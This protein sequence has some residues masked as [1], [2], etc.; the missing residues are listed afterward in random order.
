ME[1]IKEDVFNEE[2]KENEDYIQLVATTQIF[3]A[4]T[5]NNWKVD[6]GFYIINLKKTRDAID[7][8]LNNLLEYK[9]VQEEIIE[10]KFNQEIS[11]ILGSNLV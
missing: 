5:Q 6:S 11:D 10:K 4:K 7:K 1:N 8:K 2:M 3:S 9:K